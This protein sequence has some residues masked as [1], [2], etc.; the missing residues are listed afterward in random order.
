M[1]Q[2]LRLYI[3]AAYIAG[4][5][6]LG[7]SV[8][9]LVSSRMTALGLMMIVL[10]LLSGWIRIDH[11]PSGYVDLTPPMIFVT[12]L[13]VGPSTAF[14]AAVFSTVLSSRFLSHKGW[15]EVVTETGE[16]GMATLVALFLAR[17]MG[18]TL[19]ML[20]STSGLFSFLLVAWAYAVVKIALTG[21]RA[22]LTE[23]ISPISFVRESGKYMSGHLAVFGVLALALIFLYRRLGYLSLPLAA[24][25]AIEFYLPAKLIRDQRNTLFAYLGVLAS[26]IDSKDEYT[27]THLHFV[28]TIAVRIARAMGLPEAE[29]NR[30]RIGALMHD[31]GK[32]GVSAKIIRKPAALDPAERAMMMRHPAIGAE[33]MQPVELL[34]EAAE[35]VLHCHEYYDGSGYPD[36]LKDDTIPIGSRVILVADA[37]DAMTRDRSYRKARSREEAFRELIRNAGTQFDPKVVDAFRAVIDRFSPIA[38]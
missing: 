25:T 22:N 35:I 28:E 15:L 32:V 13:L 11:D 31:I 14:F 33:I 1:N 4:V 27:A 6:V 10:T 3:A 12:L 36:G 9:F 24:V 21:V 34:S 19:E 29:V 18:L 20:S 26:A 23:R 7:A 38:A 17:E 2:T 37:F 5:F 8:G 16:Q 30:I